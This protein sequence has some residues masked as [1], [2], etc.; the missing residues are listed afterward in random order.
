[1]ITNKRLSVAAASAALACS[2]LTVQAA[3]NGAAASPAQP[4]P[5][6]PNIVFVVAD[7]LGWADVS[8]GRPNRGSGNPYNETPAI[9]RLAEQGVAFDNAY[10]GP[11]CVPTRALSSPGSTRPGPPT[12]CT[13]S[14]ISTAAATTRCSTARPG[15]AERRRV[16]RGGLHRR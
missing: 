9:D 10:A 13:W 14:V 5:G 2:P 16:P 4:G 1:M 3:Q 6:R 15:A 7:D 11:N 12:T 8:T